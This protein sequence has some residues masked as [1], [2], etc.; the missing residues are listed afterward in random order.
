MDLFRPHG[1]INMFLTKYQDEAKT[2]HMVISF[3]DT[4]LSKM[5]YWPGRY[6]QFKLNEL[7]DWKVIKWAK[8][9]GY[10]Y[11]DFE[12]IDVMTAKII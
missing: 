8:A 9:Q 7:L 5:R 3:G 10:R 11:Y 6:G 4:L 1:Y 12:G 2:V